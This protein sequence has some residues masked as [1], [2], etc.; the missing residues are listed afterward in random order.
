MAN[1]HIGVND[2]ARNISSIQIGVDNIARKVSNGYIGINN[3][4]RKFFQAVQNGAYGSKVIAGTKTMWSKV[5]FDGI[6][7]IV[8][9][10]SGSTYTLM[11]YCIDEITQFGS[12]STYSGS[13]IASKCTTFQNSMS[14]EALSV[15]NSKTVQN[16]TAKVWIATK[17]SIVS[18]TDSSSPTSNE[19]GKVRKWDYSDPT[20]DGARNGYYWCSDPDGG[21]V[22]I[23]DYYGNISGNYPNRY[24][25]FRPCIE[26]TQ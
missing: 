2:T 19:Y 23:F 16:V 21:Y 8:V 17:S 24:Y 22:W 7:W 13:T 4:A 3:V 26:V 12:S 9:N 25:G 11:K 6:D 14:A 1:A 18:W 20:V 15:V 5:Q 10:I